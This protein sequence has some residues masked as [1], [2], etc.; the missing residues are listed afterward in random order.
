MAEE[1]ES[2]IGKVVTWVAGVA[3]TIISS[4]AIWYF[5]KPAPAPPPPP[6][7]V[8]TKFEGM[9]Y[10]GSAPVAKAMVVLDL[11]GDPA[12]NGDYHDITDENGAYSI[13]LTGL[14][15]GIGA[16]VAASAQG[17]TNAQPQAMASPLSTDERMDIS[18]TPVVAVAEPEAPPAPLH[19]LQHPPVEAPHRPVYRP[20]QVTKAQ[21]RVMAKQ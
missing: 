3:A 17:F 10:S 13:E 9:V 15:Q 12:A 16:Q 5:T 7:P 6:P 1:K 4:V 8:V 18:L 20:K 21:F 19:G 14:P 2:G 11:T